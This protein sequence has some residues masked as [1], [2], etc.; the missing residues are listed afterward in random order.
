MDETMIYDLL[1]IGGGIN[2][3][4]I[5]ADAAGRGLSVYLCEKDDLANHTSAASSKMIHGGLRYLEYYE[6]RLIREALEER[7]VLL[8]IAPHIIEPLSL[9]IPHNTLQRPAWLIRLGL[10]FYDHLGFRWGHKSRLAKSKS[11]DLSKESPENN[12][13]KSELTKGFIY[14]DC[15]VDDARLVVLNALS[16]KSHGASINTHTEFLNATREAGSW[17]VELKNSQGNF[18]VH[19]KGLVNAAGPWVSEVVNNR[20]AIETEH[21]VDLVKG[22]H[23]VFP[24]LYEGTQAYLLQH[25]DS[26][27]VF[28][29]PYHDNFTMVGTTDIQYTGD[30]NTVSVDTS[31]R[32]YLCNIVNHYFKK[33]V[34][35]DDIVN[36][37]SGVRPLQA[38]DK[39]N[40]SAI[41]RDYV[42]EIEDEAGKLPI[43]SIFGGKITT[44]RRLAEHALEQL[45]AYFPQMG[46]A[47]T[48]TQ[49]LPGGDLAQGMSGLIQDLSAAY[50]ELPIHLLKRLAQYGNLSYQILGSAKTLVDLGQ[51]FSENLYQAEVDYLIREEWAQSVEDILWRRTKL[52]LITTHTAVTDL[53]VYLTVVRHG[54]VA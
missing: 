26:R 1:I 42:L 40:P 5:A 36:E 48:G 25:P 11:I 50:P 4:G 49:P 35:V 13:L 34:T 9:L 24:K 15:R 37:W 17:R 30:P 53:K 32:E 2:G 44:Y 3:C 43:L 20:I 54:L 31:E 45:H 22:S 39:A 41:T 14:S 8:N 28:V 46:P 33:T 23:I 10:W 6:F 19:A 29:I 12:P 16:A 7:D 21:H 47:W 52:G 27:V 51:A 18:V 38:Q